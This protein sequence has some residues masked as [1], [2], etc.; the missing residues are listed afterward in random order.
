MDTLYPHAAGL[1]VHK[2]S[3]YA[4]VR[5]LSPGGQVRQHPQEVG[6]FAGPGVAPAKVDAGNHHA[7]FANTPDSINEWR[8]HGP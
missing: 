4:C 5:H 1:D 3:I 7:L 2:L 6:A 8:G